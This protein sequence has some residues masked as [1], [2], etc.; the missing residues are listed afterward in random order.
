MVKE[1]TGDRCVC[2]QELK[3]KDF[4]MFSHL[5]ITIAH[6]ETVSYILESLLEMELHCGVTLLI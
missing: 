4:P 1:V 3:G 6:P 2:R 5:Q